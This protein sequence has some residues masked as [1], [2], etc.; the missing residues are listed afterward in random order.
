MKR[1]CHNSTEKAT[2]RIIAE[3]R[4]RARQS[5]DSRTR[6]IKITPAY[7]GHGWDCWEYTDGGGS[8]LAEN[9]PWHVAMHAGALFMRDCLQPFGL[10]PC[11][12]IRIG[13][14]SNLD[15]NAGVTP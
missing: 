13:H 14:D 10:T 1:E 5:L 11:V 12:E 6:E 15:Q 2:R 9:V 3:A 7:K 4:N 8:L